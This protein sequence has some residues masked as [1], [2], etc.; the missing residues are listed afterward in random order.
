MVVDA[1][2]L[3]HPAS[4]KRPQELETLIPEGYTI[5]LALRSA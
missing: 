2:A 5:E 3:Q 4:L 1:C